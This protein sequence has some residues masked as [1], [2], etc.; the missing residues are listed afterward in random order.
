MKTNYSIYCLL[1]SKG[2]VFY[3]GI[4]K[5]LDIRLYEHTLCDK[6]N[7][8]RDREVR[9]VVDELGYLPYKST[10]NITLEEAKKLEKKLIKKYRPQ[11]TNKHAGGNLVEYQPKI[12]KPRIKIKQRRR[13]PYCGRLF[14]HLGKHKCEEKK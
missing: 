14:L 11:L 13:C 8:D 6:K 3:V 2:F 4:T 1:N 9:K 7:K 12:K 5:N 10:S